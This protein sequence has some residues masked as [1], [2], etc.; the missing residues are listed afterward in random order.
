MGSKSARI[1]TS[2][3]LYTHRS[4]VQPKSESEPASGGPELELELELKPDAQ[5]GRHSANIAATAFGARV[6]DHVEK[7]LALL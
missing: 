3:K 4:T 5:Q 7:T 2:T 1:G 6:A